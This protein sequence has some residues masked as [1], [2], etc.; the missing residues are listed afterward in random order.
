[1]G[2]ESS[3]I[4]FTINGTPYQAEEGMTWQEFVES[5]YNDGSININT[6]YGYVCQNNQYLANTEWSYVM[7][8]DTIMI[9]FNYQY[10]EM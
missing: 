3:L 4:E 1:M 5:S 2:G 9:G 7:E 6:K 10:L 8:A